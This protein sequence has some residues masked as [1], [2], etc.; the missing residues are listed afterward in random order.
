MK[1]DKTVKVRLSDDL[2]RRLYY[3]ANAEH[4]TP[5][6]HIIHMLRQNI[7][8]FERVHGKIPPQALRDVNIDSDDNDDG[9]AVTQR[10][11]EQ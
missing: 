7:A 6:N 2:C 1:N 11:S 8:Y 10:G 5:N 3:I 9:D 4:R